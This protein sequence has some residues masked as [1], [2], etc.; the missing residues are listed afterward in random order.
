MSKVLIDKDDARSVLKAAWAALGDC[1]RANKKLNGVVNQDLV[2]AIERLT[3]LLDNDL[4]P[5]VDDLID[6]LPGEGDG[7]END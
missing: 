6:Y 7:N 2:E 1:E 4:L 3:R 5:L